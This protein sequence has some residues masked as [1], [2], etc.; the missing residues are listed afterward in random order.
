MLSLSVW[1]S[2][3]FGLFKQRSAAVWGPALVG[4]FLFLMAA[5]QGF[6]SRTGNPNVYLVIGA[7]ALVVFLGNI[8]APTQD[9]LTARHRAALSFAGHLVKAVPG[10]GAGEVIAAIEHEDLVAECVQVLRESARSQAAS[11]EDAYRRI[12][13]DPK[14]ASFWKEEGDRIYASITPTHEAIRLLDSRRG[15]GADGDFGI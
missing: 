6:V 10:N 1:S 14:N 2:A 5:F 11:A 15:R 7:V 9:D 8:V 4:A 3:L 13:S 12:S